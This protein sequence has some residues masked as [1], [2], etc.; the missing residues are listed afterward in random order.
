[1][2]RATRKPKAAHQAIVM[3]RL[4]DIRLSPENDVLYKPVDF[5]DPAIIALAESIRE[6]G[7]REPLVLSTD[8]YILSGHR[9]YAAATLAI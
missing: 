3:V 2:T 6:H 7:L 9:R 5:S 8:S 4:C 1:M